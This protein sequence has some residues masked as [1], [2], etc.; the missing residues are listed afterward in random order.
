MKKIVSYLLIYSIFGLSTAVAQYD[1]YVWEPLTP[2]KGAFG[3]V[4]IGGD[5]LGVGIGARY[6]FFGLNI[7]LTG[8]A[9]STP[10][11]AL[12]APSGVNIIRNQPLPSGFEEERFLSMMIDADL[13]LYFDLAE[14]ISFNASIG[15]YSKNDTILAKNIQ[16]GSRFIYDNET[17]SGLCFGLGAEYV[18]Q[19]SINVGAGYHTQRG[20]LFRLTYLWF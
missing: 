10:A 2:I 17:E 15:F 20:I 12:Q 13:M 5:G 16:N 11:Y 14:T 9:N 4:S 3:D 1:K 18:L 8:L 7:G 19:E 6:M